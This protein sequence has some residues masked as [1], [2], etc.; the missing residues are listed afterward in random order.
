MGGRPGA[1]AACTHACAISDDDPSSASA[2][3]GALEFTD[4]LRRIGHGTATV[5]T[6]HARVG[7]PNHPGGMMTEHPSSATVVRVDGA[8]AMSNTRGL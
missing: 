3:I 6:A 2:E 4:G 5:Q 8:G 1:G 7:E